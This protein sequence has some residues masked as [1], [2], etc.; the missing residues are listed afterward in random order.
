[1][2]S[3]ILLAFFVPTTVLLLLTSCHKDALQ[4]KLPSGQVALTFDDAS[5][6]NWHQYLP[7]LDSLNIKATFYV[8]AYHTFNEE[9]KRMLKEIEAQGHEIAYHTANHLDLAKEVSKNGMAKTEANE[10]NSDLALMKAD[11]YNITN[12]AYPFGSHSTQLNNCL[13]RK[14]KSVRAL[15]NHQNYNKSLVKEAGSWKVLYGANIDNNSHLKE[16]GIASL[17]DKAKDRNTCLVLVAHQINN[18]RIALQITR[19]RLQ[20]I[21]KAALARNLEFVTVNRIAK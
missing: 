19:E 10:I 14:F 4:G 1:M 11:G 6:E 18:R 12:F 13:L 7:L 21:S 16:D 2:Y 5:V 9:Q 17:M 20:F 15:S 8:S 3:R